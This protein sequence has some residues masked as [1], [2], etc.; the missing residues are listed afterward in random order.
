M[1][2]LTELQLEIMEYIQSYIK[3]VNKPVPRSLIMSV[4]SN[5]S[6]KTLH[7]RIKALITKGYIKKAVG[8]G[9]TIGY[10]QL[11]RI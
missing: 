4:F 9:I 1:E 11:R 2:K 5:E 10:I 3:Q 7:N 8:H 6:E